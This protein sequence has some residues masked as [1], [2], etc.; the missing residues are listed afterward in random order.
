VRG[1]VNHVLCEVLAGSLNLMDFLLGWSS[2]R[3]NHKCEIICW[4]RDL[5]L[6]IESDWR[7]CITVD[8]IDLVNI[9]TLDTTS[10]N[11]AQQRI[12]ADALSDCQTNSEAQARMMR[13]ELLHKT[14]KSCV[15]RRHEQEC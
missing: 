5:V 4:T 6:M 10:V 15:D 11:S 1:I 13:F 3:L 8:R 7:V 14:R 9:W 12:I 2:I